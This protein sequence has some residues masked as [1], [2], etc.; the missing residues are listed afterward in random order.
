MVTTVRSAVS[1]KSQFVPVVIPEFKLIVNAQRPPV[2]YTVVSAEV[3]NVVL[4]PTTAVATAGLNT[5]LI[6]AAFFSSVVLAVL[7]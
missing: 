4:A 7:L 6:P 2:F 1:A 3:H 5:A